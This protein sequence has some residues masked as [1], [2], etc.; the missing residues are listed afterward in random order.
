MTRLPK[1]SYLCLLIALCLGAGPALADET[2]DEPIAELGAPAA[3]SQTP[4]APPPAEPAAADPTEEFAS[5][6]ADWQDRR[7]WR[8]G[9]QHFFALSRGMEDAGVPKLGRPFLYVVTVPFDIAFLP[10]AAISGLFGN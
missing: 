9:T 5:A 1:H 3:E 8:Y 4:A 7:S 2:T 10:T 6:E